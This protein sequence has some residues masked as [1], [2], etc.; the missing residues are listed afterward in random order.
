[1]VGWLV[2]WLA[3]RRSVK[4]KEGE[5]EREGERRGVEGSRKGERQGGRE[6]G[7][8]VGWVMGGRVAKG[9]HHPSTVARL[10]VYQDV[11]ERCRCVFDFTGKFIFAI[12]FTWFLTVCG[13]YCSGSRRV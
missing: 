11:L 13:S 10:F 9:F 7:T 12:V 4:E 1:M 2:G 6:A 8:L 5:G 3:G